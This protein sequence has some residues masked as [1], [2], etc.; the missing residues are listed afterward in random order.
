M[1]TTNI[2]DDQILSIGRLYQA[3]TT[4]DNMV[5]Q[6]CVM[7]LGLTLESE[8]MEYAKERLARIIGKDPTTKP[9]FDTWML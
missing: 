4:H 1:K 8:G 3:D 6:L 7:A 9:L 2:S 5:R